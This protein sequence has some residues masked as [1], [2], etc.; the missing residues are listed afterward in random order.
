MYRKQIIMDQ[1][2]VS[3]QRVKIKHNLIHIP[4]TVST[5][6]TPPELLPITDDIIEI[7]VDDTNYDMFNKESVLIGLL[8][9]TKKLKKMP[10]EQAIYI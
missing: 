10:A 8:L 9:A 3:P 5:Q 4:N 6:Y 2:D 1:M 7:K